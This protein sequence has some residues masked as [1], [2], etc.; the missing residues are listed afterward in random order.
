MSTHL[1][2][3][4]GRPPINDGLS[5]QRRW[6]LK[7]RA[8]NRCQGCG[9]PKPSNCVYCDKCGERYRIQ[10]REAR[11]HKPWDPILRNG[12]KPKHAVKI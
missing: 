12:R 9:K 4:M 10:V 5:R 2:P 6:Q 8:N 3:K 7:Q 1:K 11:G